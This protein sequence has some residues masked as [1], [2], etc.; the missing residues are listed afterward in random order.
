M[1]IA[2]LPCAGSCCVLPVNYLIL[3]YPDIVWLTQM[4]MGPRY[5]IPNAS[6]LQRMLPKFKLRVR[7]S[8]WRQ[9]A[10]HLQA[11]GIST[12]GE[13]LVEGWGYHPLAPS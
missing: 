4:E 5:T 8:P 12:K 6:Q 3:F 11:L 13:G 2:W 7:L 9:N 1:Y 10:A